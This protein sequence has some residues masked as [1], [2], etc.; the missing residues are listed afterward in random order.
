MNNE[1][2]SGLQRALGVSVRFGCARH[3]SHITKVCF[4]QILA[5]LLPS[6][7]RRL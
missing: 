5:D 2:A 7:A 1:M 3:V 6:A 4:D